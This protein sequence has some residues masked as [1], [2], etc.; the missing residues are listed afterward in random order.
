MYRLVMSAY[1]VANFMRSS[2]R[3]LVRKGYVFGISHQILERHIFGE[4]QESVIL[5][6][7]AKLLVDKNIKRHPA[8]HLFCCQSARRDSITLQLLNS[9]L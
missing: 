3:R 5:T 6:Q 2:T 9:L 1:L 8:S 4:F 7:P